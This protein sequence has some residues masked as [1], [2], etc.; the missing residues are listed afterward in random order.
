MGSSKTSNL[1][2]L[3]LV[4]QNNEMFSKQQTVYF[5]DK[6]K[7]YKTRWFSGLTM[8]WDVVNK[9]FFHC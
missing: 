8:F 1:S 9:S 7:K 3:W 2:V 4:F 6:N 5:W